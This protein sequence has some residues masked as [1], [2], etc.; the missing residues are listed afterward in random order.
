MLRGDVNKMT[1]RF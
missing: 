1:N